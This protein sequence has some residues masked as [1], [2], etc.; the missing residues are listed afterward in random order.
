MGRVQLWSCGGGRQSAGIA[1]LIVQGRLPKPDHAA[2]VKIEWEVETVWPY[3]DSYIRPAME[4]VG[5]PFTV[6]S[7]KEFATKDFYDSSGR[8]YLPAFSDQSGELSK[9]PEFCSGN[10]KR[11]AMLRWGAT[12]PG[13]KKRGVDV[14]VGITWE[15]RNRRRAP[16]KQWFQ[17]TYPL[18]DIAPTHVS[19]CLQAIAEI[20]WPPPPRSRCRHCPNQSDAE[21][22]SLS[23]ADLA[24]ACE[25]DD[26]IRKQDPN[27]FLH[28]Q[29]IPLRQV[30]L[31]PKT[32]G[33][34]FSGGCSSGMCY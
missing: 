25:L 24:A 21:W 8:L 17:P 6:V 31:N 5:V 23:P 33:G 30:V 29:L 11:E 4:Q 26:E 13:W 15:E 1:A 20:G 27:V 3:V 9:L 34:L 7:R 18:L 16:R 32:D 14:W 19:G 12:Q 2:M 10:W 28:K 22:A